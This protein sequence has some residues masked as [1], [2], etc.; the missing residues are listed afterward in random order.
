MSTIL[1]DRVVRG[2]AQADGNIGRGRGCWTKSNA[3]DPPGR[4]PRRTE[5]RTATNRWAHRG[6]SEGVLVHPTDRMLGSAMTRT[7]KVRE[8]GC[9]RS[10]GATRAA[11]LGVRAS[12]TGDRVEAGRGCP[13]VATHRGDGDRP[14]RCH[15][16][17]RSVPVLGGDTLDRVRGRRRSSGPSRVASSGPGVDREVTAKRCEPR[18]DHLPFRERVGAPWSPTSPTEVSRQAFEGVVLPVATLV[19][20]IR[21]D[22]RFQ[23]GLHGI[24]AA[25]DDELV[26]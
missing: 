25:R 24:K 4:A 17:R 21:G 13:G 11:T 3:S 9:G 19:V 26:L 14:R 12:R 2:A 7:P 20:S 6:D 23:M 1:R 22:D 15:Q 16:P 10:S 18:S 8:Q 5:R